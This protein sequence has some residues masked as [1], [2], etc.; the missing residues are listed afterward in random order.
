[1]TPRELIDAFLDGELTPEQELELRAWLR[2]K[3]EHARIFV[4]E[5]HLHH[6]IGSILSTDPARLTRPAADGGAVPAGAAR[7]AKHA[8]KAPA[9]R[10]HPLVKYAA[11]PLAAAA[12]IM[13]IFYWTRSQTQDE[14][15]GQ[16]EA[17]VVAVEGGGAERGSQFVQLKKGD[18][19]ELRQTIR[20]GAE[21]WVELAYADGSTFK[22]SDGAAASLDADE[23]MQAKR[24]KL[25][26]GLLQADVKPQPV[27]AALS[28][29]TPHARTKVIGTAFSLRA[30]KTLTRLEVAHGKVEMRLLSGDKAAEVA[31]G[32]YSE[33][34]EGVQLT[35][36]NLADAPKATPAINALIN[37][38]FEEL[39]KGWTTAGPGITIGDDLHRS[40]AR[41][42]R[43]TFKKQLSTL[44]FQ[45]VPV[46]SGA[47]YEA[48][49][50]IKT[51]GASG[52]GAKLAIIWLNKPNAKHEGDQSAVVKKD[53]L[54]GL[55][56]TN[57]WQRFSGQYAAP[58]GAVVARIALTAV[59]DADGARIFFDDLHFGRVKDPP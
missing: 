37:P 34:G 12:S 5:T 17:Q 20:T 6:Q 36:N 33:A 39:I 28:I 52:D 11:L 46:E 26:S 40:G 30:T 41:C 54:G 15:R 57:D 21:G 56:G 23:T 42:L 24:I 51:S 3:P 25:D 44:A 38:G 47:T 58:A 31:S 4:R 29:T 27:G 9:R 59:M 18:R 14:T 16:V 8:S 7:V 43:M 19:I 1:M 35:V 10:I 2:D 49:G 50:W 32:Q 13:L 55:N 45:D 53:V 48:A 22:L